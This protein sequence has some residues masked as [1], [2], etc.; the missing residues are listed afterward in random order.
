[1]PPRGGGAR[2]EGGGGVGTEVSISRIWARSRDSIGRATREKPLAG[3]GIAIVE[4]SPGRR[5][6]RKGLRGG[7]VE[8]PSPGSSKID[9]S[10][11]GGSSRGRRGGKGSKGGGGSGHG[12]KGGAAVGGGSSRGGAAASAGIGSVFDAAVAA[13]GAG[14]GAGLVTLGN[15]GAS[16]TGQLLH[17]SMPWTGP[18]DGSLLVPPHSVSASAYDPV[19][20]LLQS[21]K[22]GG[23][24]SAFT[25]GG[26]GAPPPFGAQQQAGGGVGAPL[27]LSAGGGGGASLPFGAAG[28]GG[29]ASLPF[30]VGGGG[31]LPAGGRKRLRAQDRAVNDAVKAFSKF[32]NDV[33][34]LKPPRV[35]VS[36]TPPE[37]LEPAIPIASRA[38][39]HAVYILMDT[40][41]TEFG[42]SDPTDMSKK[43][44]YY[45]GLARG[46]G[47]NKP[48]DVN[49]NPSLI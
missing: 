2:R 29:S 14:M 34:A 11:I 35:N 8:G 16:D 22:G 7:G 49:P 46:A 44:V 17:S 18:A 15:E 40:A 33:L 20:A 32:A 27:P 26:R 37:W 1:M 6:V 21:Y 41:R 5:V 38:A 43:L 13:T 47:F 39:G 10:S 31:A 45:L 23:A 4:H 48:P 42:A 19:R 3:P 25:A 30:G 12:S 9:M 28:G 24:S 36:A